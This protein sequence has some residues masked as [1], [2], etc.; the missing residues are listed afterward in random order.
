VVK[1]D[2]ILFKISISLVKKEERPE[3]WAQKQLKLSA[4]CVAG[5]TWRR[6]NGGYRCEGV[7]HLVTDELLTEGKGVYYAGYIGSPFGGIRGPF[8]GRPGTTT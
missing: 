3:A 7:N 6:T 8:Y 5:F 2:H 1:L 4:T